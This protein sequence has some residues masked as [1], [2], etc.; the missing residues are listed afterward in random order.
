M[1]VENIHTVR[2]S[3]DVNAIGQITHFKWQFP[4]QVPLHGRGVFNASRNA[5]TQQSFAPANTNLCSFVGDRL[6]YTLHGANSSTKRVHVSRCRTPGVHHLPIDDTHARPLDEQRPD[7]RTRF[8]ET[9]SCVSPMDK[10]KNGFGS[11]RAQD[12][13]DKRHER[14]K[15]GRGRANRMSGHMSK[16]QDAQNKSLADNIGQ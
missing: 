16:E 15:N 5:H 6:V 3:C 11:R 12:A 4:K 2:N 7:F 13:N 10:K 14:A 1:F 8:V 9:S